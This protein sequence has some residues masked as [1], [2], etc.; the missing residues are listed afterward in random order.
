MIPVFVKNPGT[1]APPEGDMYYIIAKNGI[2]LRKKTNWVDAIIPVKQIS[3]LENQ[4]V[5]AK[6][7]LRPIPEE[8]MAKVIKFFREVYKKHYSE[9]VVEFLYSEELGWDISVPVQKVDSGSAQYTSSTEWRP[10]YVRAGTAHSHGS[11]SAFHS[12]IDVPDEADRDGV[13]ITVGGLNRPDTVSLDAEIIVSGTRISLSAKWIEGV[14]DYKKDEGGKEGSGWFRY[15]NEKNLYTIS[16]NTV[17]NW[18][19]PEDWMNKVSKKEYEYYRYTK[20]TSSDV[21]TASGAEKESGSIETDGEKYGVDKKKRTPRTRD[22]YGKQKAEK[23][24]EERR[25]RNLV[26][27]RRRPYDGVE[28]IRGLLYYVLTEISK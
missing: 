25:I 8:V 18:E 2:F 15:W 11:M 5:A 21:K 12:G 3:I 6:L 7:L 17:M 9:A 1:E 4:E 24:E 16:D 13:H 26:P 28:G 27:L 10:G 20:T 19:V 23:E 22:E 14:Q